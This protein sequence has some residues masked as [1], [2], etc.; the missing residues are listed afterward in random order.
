MAGELRL[1]SVRSRYPGFIWETPQRRRRVMRNLPAPDGCS[2]LKE[3]L[4]TDAKSTGLRKRTRLSPT[5][6]TCY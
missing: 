4:D 6:S 5:S 2:G 3:M 1:T